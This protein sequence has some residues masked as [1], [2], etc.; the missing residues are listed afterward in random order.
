MKEPSPQLFNMLVLAGVVL[1]VQWKNEA[2]PKQAAEQLLQI[3]E[4]LGDPALIME[5]HRSY[6][7]GP[8]RAGPLR[9][10]TPNTLISASES[11]IEANRNHPYSLTIAHDCK[12]V[13]ECFAARAL[14]ALGDSDGAL[15]RM[16]GASAFASRA[17]SPGKPRYSQLTLPFNF[18][19]C[20]A[21][22]GARPRASR[23]EVVKLADEYGLDLWQALG[24]ID[25]GWAEA[26]TWKQR[27]SGIDQM[28][29]GMT[30][31]HGC[32]S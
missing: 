11:C 16:Q 17:F 4:T 28:Q 15:K 10:G 5:A 2:L 18:I 7:L 1:Q 19:R 29:R 23:S 22:R 31:L 30:G 26:A 13:S 3:A 6:G 14:W 25:L 8:D 12:V 20:E 21:N 32:R 9:R 24:N 27:R